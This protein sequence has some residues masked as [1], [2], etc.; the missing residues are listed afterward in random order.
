MHTKSVNRH[1]YFVTTICL[2]QIWKCY[3][4][5]NEI[6]PSRYLLFVFAPVYITLVDHCDT[7]VLC[8]SY[9]ILSGSSCFPELCVYLNTIL[10][11]DT[12][13]GQIHWFQGILPQFK[14]IFKIVLL[15]ILSLVKY[16]NVCQRMKSWYRNHVETLTYT[17]TLS[18]NIFYISLVSA[19]LSS[20]W[21]R[22]ALSDTRI[23]WCFCSKIYL[24]KK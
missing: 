5:T 18:L 15:Y 13:Y 3:K 12:L 11:V 19:I 4:L 9:D 21:C 8:I 2:H 23:F 10:L 16:V 7:F 22:F 1:F 14:F 6:W 20:E 24:F 17:N